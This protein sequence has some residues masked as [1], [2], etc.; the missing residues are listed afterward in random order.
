MRRLRGSV[1]EEFEGDGIGNEEI[2]RKR[3]RM[4]R[5]DEIGKREDEI[6]K[7]GREREKKNLERKEDWEM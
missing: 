2:E 1:R 3:K 7:L 6:G 4:G 5:E